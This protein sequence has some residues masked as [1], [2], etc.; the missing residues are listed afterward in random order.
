LERILDRLD[1]G[2]SPEN[3]VR[4]ALHLTYADLNTATADY[5]RK[6]H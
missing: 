1:E 5:L 6:L 4:A 3:A 2:A